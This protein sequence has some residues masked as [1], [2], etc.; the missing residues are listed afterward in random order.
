[1]RGRF[2]P[3]DGQLYVDWPE[4]LADERLR[5]K[6]ASTACVAPVKPLDLPVALEHQRAW[7]LP[8]VL[9]TE[10]DAETRRPTPESYSVEVW[11]YLYSQNYGSPELSVLEPDRKSGARQA[12]PRPVRR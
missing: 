5:A 8:D 11:N 4:G 7:C 2:S 1:M 12:E 6:V 10:L 3:I 9:L